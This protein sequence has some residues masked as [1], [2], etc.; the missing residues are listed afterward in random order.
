MQVTNELLAKVLDSHG[1]QANWDLVSSIT[2]EVVLGGPFWTMRGWPEAELRQTVSLDARR[3]HVTTAPFGGPEQMSVFDVDPERL[4]IQTIS[5][6]IVEERDDPR[7]SFPPFD[8][9]TTK[10]DP[11]QIAYFGSAANWNY[12]TQPFSLTYPGVE[13][14]E[15]EPWHEAGATW[16]RLAVTF[17]PSNANHNAD[18]VFYYD[19]DFML[20]RMDYA[21]DV[22]GNALVAHYTDEPKTFDGFVFPTRRH[23]HLRGADGTADR[24][25]ALITLDV[26]T[27]SMDRRRA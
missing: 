1:G 11:I 19:T 5:G 24:S 14:D 13:V 26:S 12:L 21:P 8:V 2:A 9:E 15:I 23:V 4:A 20:R 7:S 10:W 16:R 17:P 22:A 27:V 6:H 18:Q 3:Q 25:F